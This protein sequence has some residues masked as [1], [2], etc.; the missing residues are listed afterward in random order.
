MRLGLRLPHP[1]QLF[2]ANQRVFIGGILMIEL[3]LHEASEPAEFG[4][5]F[6]EQIHL[7]HR[8]EHRRHLAAALQEG[9]KGF[10]HVLVVQEIAVHQAKVRC[11]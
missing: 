11:G 3:V 8:A 2:K 7:M 1:V 6:A 10:A 9:Q 4:N 5:V